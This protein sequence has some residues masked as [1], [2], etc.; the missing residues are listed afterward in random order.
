MT[1]LEA[2]QR[3]TEFLE[4]KGV[5]SPRLQSE[6]L[7]GHVLKKK[8]LKLYLEHGSELSAEATEKFRELIR[9]RGLR[10][11]LQHLLG[12]AEFCGIELKVT[13][14]VLIPRPETE[15]LAEQGWLF[16]NS[17]PQEE[18]RFL[19]FGSGSG[20]LAI[21]LVRHSAKARGIALDRSAEALAVAE[22]NARSTGVAERL[23]FVQSDGFSEI[24][25][26]VQFDLIISNPPYIPSAEIPSLQEEVRR[27]DPPLALDGGEDGLRFYRILAEQS[28]QFLRPMAKIMLEFGDGQEEA[29]EELFSSHN[30]IVEKILPDYSGR[31]RMLIA[32]PKR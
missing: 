27:F 32:R 29:L 30:W 6:L 26:G 23:E 13:P 16:L 14:A 22:E 18:C 31:A 19:D 24:R 8:R 21:S 11:P 1:V 15:L 20:C 3:S 5:D 7:L 9:R 10:E 2:I 12:S 4:K 28:G 25:P 17:L